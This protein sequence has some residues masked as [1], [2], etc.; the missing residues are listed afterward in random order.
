M[1]AV[2]ELW[3]LVNNAGIATAG[4]VELLPM[5]VFERSF[6]I[7]QTGTL[8][9]TKSVIGMVRRAQGQS[10]FLDI[11]RYFANA[12]LSGRVVTITSGIARGNMGGRASYCM[13]KAA[14]EAMNNCLRM[15]MRRFGVKASVVRYRAE[16][17]FI[18]V[19]GDH[20]RARKLHRQHCNIWCNA[21]SNRASDVT[22]VAANSRRIL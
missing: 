18:D 22:V 9:A 17:C 20:Y 2:A 15:E 6:N 11:L 10:S 5:E 21:C 14:L 19:A 4:H 12:R 8:R 13:A 16:Q 7:N 1:H 3:A